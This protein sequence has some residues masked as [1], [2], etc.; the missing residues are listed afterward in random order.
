MNYHLIALKHETYKKLNAFFEAMRK[1]SGFSRVSMDQ[2]VQ[3][4][5]QNKKGCKHD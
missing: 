4:L 2:V 3:R 1:E 5:L